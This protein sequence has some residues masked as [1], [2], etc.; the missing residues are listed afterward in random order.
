MSTLETN[1]IGKYSTNNVSVDDALNL[2][3][4]TE[5]QRDALTAVNGTIIYNTTTNQF[6][7]RENGA[8][9]LKINF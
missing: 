3:S 6:N 8:W 1:A 4:Y 9:V 5:A 2:K 7:F